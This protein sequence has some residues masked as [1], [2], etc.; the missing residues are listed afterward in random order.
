[1]VVVLASLSATFAR[2]PGTV[3]PALQSCTSN[4]VARVR[5]EILV[6]PRNDEAILA[7]DAMALGVDL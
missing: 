7:P 3:L 2:V 6:Y 4:P 5:I 1:M